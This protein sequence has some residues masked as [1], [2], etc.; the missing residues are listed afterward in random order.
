M[1]LLRR[2]YLYNHSSAPFT[3]HYWRLGNSRRDVIFHGQGPLGRQSVFIC[4]AWVRKISN[5]GRSFQVFYDIPDIQACIS[6]SVSS[7]AE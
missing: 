4:F 3:A 5:H 6:V 1:E 7:S 2:L